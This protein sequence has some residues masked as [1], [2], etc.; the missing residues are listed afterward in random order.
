[1]LYTYFILHYLVKLLNS[2]LT[3]IILFTL[4]VHFPCCEDWYIVHLHVMKTIIS[5]CT[6]NVFIL[7]SPRFS[8]FILHFLIGFLSFPFFNFKSSSS[9]MKGWIAMGLNKRRYEYYNT[10]IIKILKVR[11]AGDMTCRSKIFNWEY[12]SNATK[13]MMLT[14]SIQ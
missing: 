13:F 6:L 10:K 12:A 3:L 14:I 2:I 5:A 4:I 9:A 7:S 1:M 8:C 11:F